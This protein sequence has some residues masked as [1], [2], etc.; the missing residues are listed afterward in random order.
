MFR[1]K[2]LSSRDSFG[3]NFLTKKNG[4]K[5]LKKILTKKMDFRKVISK[6]GAEKNRSK[7]ISKFLTQKIGFQKSDFKISLIFL[8]RNTDDLFT[9]FFQTK[10]LIFYFF[11]SGKKSVLIQFEMCNLNFWQFSYLLWRVPTLKKW[12]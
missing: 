1:I 4:S 7:V 12:F 6:F 9:F 11:L 8:K 3:E 2:I 5:L 10:I